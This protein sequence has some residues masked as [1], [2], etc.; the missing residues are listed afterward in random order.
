MAP[1]QLLAV[2][3]AGW[4]SRQQQQVIEYLREENRVLREKLGK[5]GVL[6]NDDQRRRVP[7]KC[8]A[9]PRIDLREPL[10]GHVPAPARAASRV[11]S[12]CPC[13]L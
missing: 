13:E 12:P 5:K 9:A 1:W 2:I 8:A 7:C 3:V 11:C 4:M 6:L 10:L